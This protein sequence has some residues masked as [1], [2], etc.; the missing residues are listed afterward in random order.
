MNEGNLASAVEGL[1][2]FMN[3]SDEAD[4]VAG[5]AAVIQT[6]LP[7]RLTGGEIQSNAGHFFLKYDLCHIDM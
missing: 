2:T 7:E 5:S 3:G 6:S 4:A 1:G